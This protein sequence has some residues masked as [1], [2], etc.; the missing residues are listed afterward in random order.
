MDKKKYL[1]I[2]QTA[3]SKVVKRIDVTGNGDRAID[4]VERGININL[5]HAQYHTNINDSETELPVGDF[6]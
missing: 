2:I 1:E 3:D 4:R 5:N 6:K